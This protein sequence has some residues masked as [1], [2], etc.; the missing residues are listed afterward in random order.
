MSS[1][2]PGS[3]DT[4]AT[5]FSNLHERKIAHADRHNDL[6]DAINKIEAELGINPSGS[7]ATVLARL[8]AM[9][10]S[11][12]FRT[13]YY[14]GTPGVASTVLLVQ[15]QLSYVPLEVP[16]GETLD[17]LGIETTVV[18]TAGAVIRLG[19]YADDGD[20]APGTRILDGGTVDGTILG[21]LEATISQAVAEGPL[22]LAA[23]GQGSPATQPTVRAVTGFVAG[24]GTTS[25][26]Q[27]LAARYVETGIT[28]ALPATATP[29]SSGGLGARVL[30]RAT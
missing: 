4:F 8:A 22:W 24:I 18:G 27:A 20:G 23:V 21:G 10:A 29:G 12:G 7:F 15:G 6:A 25:L 19:L 11:S 17:R 2:Y 1:G 16:K 14:Y 28:G 9:R 13:G 5:D 30:V 26:S 3:V